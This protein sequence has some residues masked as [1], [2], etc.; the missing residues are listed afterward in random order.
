VAE[1]DVPHLIDA[2]V[3]VRYLTNDPPELASYA[4]RVID[5]GDALLLSEVSL[6]ETWF[7]LTKQYRVP[8]EAAIEALASFVQKRSVRLVRL[9]KPLVLEALLLCRASARYSLADGLLWA[10]A[11]NSGARVL[12]FDRGFPADGIE[13]HQLGSPS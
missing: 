6:A 3:V 10:E 8:R 12:T 4:R 11:R 7:V 9:P 2:S 5:G 13:V 1:P